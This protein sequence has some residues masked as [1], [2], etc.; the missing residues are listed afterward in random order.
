RYAI[1]ALI[2]DSYSRG[3]TLIEL[4]VVISIVALLSSIVLSAVNSARQK[5]EIARAKEEMVQF[6]KIV[7]IAQGEANSTLMNI[8]GNNCSDCVCR[9]G[10]SLKN[11]AGTCYTNWTSILS[12]VQNSTNG[13]VTGLTNMTRDPWGSPYL[14]D[15]NQGEGGVCTS[16]DGFRSAGPD[17]IYGNSDDVTISS[18]IPLSPKCP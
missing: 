16:V 8:T 1:M 9:T 15:E 6:I 3:F 12:K 2:M 18:P 14:V 13:I 4:L 17:G 10:S 7:S 5:A 11:D